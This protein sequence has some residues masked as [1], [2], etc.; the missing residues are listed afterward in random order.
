MPEGIRKPDSDKTNRNAVINPQKGRHLL[1]TFCPYEIRSMSEGMG[2]DGDR[3]YVLFESARIK[4]GA[5]VR[6]KLEHIY[7]FRLRNAD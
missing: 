4:Y 7:S 1:C 6:E 2:A 3:I 5:F